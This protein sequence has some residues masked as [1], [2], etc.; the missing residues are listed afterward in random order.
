MARYAYFWGCYLPGRL[1]HMEK[2]IRLSMARLGLEIADLDGFTCCPEKSMVRNHGHQLWLLTAARNLALADEAG[3][4]LSTPCA[5]CFGTLAGARMEL[6]GNRALTQKINQELAAVGH[7]YTGHAKVR[8]LLDL[9][10]HEVGLTK[11]RQSVIKPLVGMRIALHHGCHLLRPSRDLA[12]DDPAHPYKFEELV[13]ALGAEVLHYDT[14]ALCCGGL[15]SRVDDE[16]LGEAMARKKLQELRRLGADALVVV[17]PSCFMQYDATQYVLQRRGEELCIP[18]FYYL[19]LLALAMGMSPEEIGLGHHRVE[20]S[21]FHRKW[22]RTLGLIAST[23]GTLDHTLISNCAECGACVRDCPVAQSD[24]TYD[25]NALI[26][27]VAQGH[28]EEV[29]SSHS[30]WKCHECYA[31]HETCWQDLAMVDIFRQLKHTVLARGQGPAPARAGFEA[32]AKTGRLIKG[33]T[34]QRK[35]LLLPPPSDSGTE[36]LARLIA[37]QKEDEHE[38]V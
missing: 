31:C 22:E 6:V 38:Q 13:Q 15:M 11:V 9:I 23:V 28:M 26:R 2:A 1:P 21:P 17:C 27:M 14:E 25:P 29:L 35:R 18:V 12:F 19:E 37:S 20:V 33:S 30:L 4:D 32:F 10:Y 8:H 36:E 34:A 16:A 3:V 5:G 7:G 24:L